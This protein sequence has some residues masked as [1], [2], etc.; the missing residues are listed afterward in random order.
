MNKEFSNKWQG[1]RLPRK[2]RK[3]LANAPLHLKRKMMAATLS[4]DLRK[5]YGFR[6]IETRK[7]DEVRIMRGKFAGKTGKVSTIVIKKMKVTIDGITHNKKD[8]TKVNV[9]IHP[10][11]LMITSLNTDDK[12]RINTKENNQTKKSEKENAPKKN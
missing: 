10:S 6:S 9:L 4:K 7:G 12:Y 11:K 3:Y 8:G 1:S 5:K 2:Q